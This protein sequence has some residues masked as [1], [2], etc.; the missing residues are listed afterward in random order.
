[1][2]LV[3][4]TSAI[5]FP[6]G[7]GF[8]QANHYRVIPAFEGAPALREM[9]RDE[10]GQFRRGELSTAEIAAWMERTRGLAAPEPP[11]DGDLPPNQVGWLVGVKPVGSR[12][13]PRLPLLVACC[14][15]AGALLAA[16]AAPFDWHG[17]AL[18]VAAL[19][20][21]LIPL[22]LVCILELA[23]CYGLQR[24]F[25]RAARPEDVA[26]VA[27]GKVV[28]LTGVIV[29]RQPSVPT[30][31]RGVPAV[32]FRNCIHNADEVRG[33]DFD[34]DLDVGQR[35]RVC[36][37]RAF[38]VDRPTP[39]PQAPACGPVYAA[40]PSEGF[41]ARLRSALLLAPSPLFRTFGAR[42]ESSV[43]PGDRVEV[44]GVLDRELAP[45]AAAPFARL[46]PT[47]FVLRAGVDRPLL[48]RRIIEGPGS[49]V[50]CERG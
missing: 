28:C 30:L 22:S 3:R 19:L 41:S 50:P 34:L 17:P 42:H 26:D 11:A 38:L 44:A 35:V 37:R 10:I 47:R 24:Q 9:S 39:A 48:V 16:C 14:A 7:A 23:A 46:I 29:R 4:L 49:A 13:H 15:G 20:G 8:N 43:G 32:L 6:P 27:P 31:F 36:V 12:L 25:A 33:I 1:V 2:A 45:D 40:P 18:I 5:A 21:A